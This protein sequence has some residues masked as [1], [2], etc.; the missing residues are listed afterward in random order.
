M[1][2]S[3]VDYAEVVAAGPELLRAESVRLS[4]IFPKFRVGTYLHCGEIVHALL[5]LSTDAA[6]LVVGADRMN[7]VT[8]VLKGSVAVQ[9]ALG[10]LAPTRIMPTGYRDGGDREGARLGHVVVGVD[11]SAEAY[12][13]VMAAAAE[14]HRMSSSLRVVIGMQP[15]AP[16]SDGVSAETAALLASLQGTYPPLVLSWA[17]DML[18]RPVRALTRHSRDAA[19]LVIGRHGRGARAGMGIGSVTRT[20]LLRPPCPTLVINTLQ[21]HTLLADTA[22][23]ARFEGVRH[24]RYGRD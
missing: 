22:A 18:R 3:G 9:V 20:L 8:G 13:A 15:D 23:T 11:G 2:R 1:M 7:T 10:S 5:G 16:Q 4:A 17:V 12:A 6:L 21:S 24:Q 14:T 19:L